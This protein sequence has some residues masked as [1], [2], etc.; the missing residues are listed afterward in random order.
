LDIG[1]GFGETLAY[2]RERGCDVYGSEVDQNANYAAE[3][4]GLNI[5]IGPYTPDNYEKDFFDYITLD[6]VIEHV[7]DPIGLLQGMHANLKEGGMAIISSPNVHG[8]GV[9]WYKKRWLHWHA[10]YHLHFFSKKSM[11]IAAHKANLKITSLKYATLSDWLYWQWIH[12]I[13]IPEINEPSLFWKYMNKN[14][15][16]DDQLKKLENLEKIRKYRFHKIITRF[17]DL[18]HLG[19]NQVFILTKPHKLHKGS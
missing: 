13:F 2:H 14:S 3:K 18:L 10:P 15:Y 7:S 9:K 17:F 11:N 19:D 1:C 6:Q 8:W 12:L 16:S 4:F 5:K